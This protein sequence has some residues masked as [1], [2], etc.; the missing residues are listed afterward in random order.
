MSRYAVPEIFQNL[1]YVD[2]KPKG[3][4]A[5]P[6]RTKKSMFGRRK[7]A[8]KKVIATKTDS[9]KE[10]SKPKSNED[11]QVSK[12]N[13]V[14][15]DAPRRS[16]SMETPRALAGGRRATMRRVD[17]EPCEASPREVPPVSRGDS[18][19]FKAARD[20]LE[21]LEHLW[22][23]PDLDRQELEKWF[24]GESAGTFV[25]RKSARFKT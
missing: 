21:K 1:N 9:K 6:E 7:T 19:D 20:A 22:L 17:S 8:P 3:K 15:A 2:L 16:A 5:E 25:C 12:T 18:T 14:P 13:V 24:D 4:P 23:F 11:A 10:S